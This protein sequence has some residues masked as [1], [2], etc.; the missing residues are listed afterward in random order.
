MRR[1][2]QNAAEFNFRTLVCCDFCSKGNNF[3]TLNQQTSTL[4]LLLLDGCWLNGGAQA[5]LP[6]L[7]L[8]LHSGP[9]FDYRCPAPLFVLVAHW[10]KLSLQWELFIT[11]LNLVLLLKLFKTSKHGLSLSHLESWR[12][13]GTPLECTESSV[14][15]IAWVYCGKSLILAL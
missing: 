4:L 5:L 14:G 1:D 12:W 8:S 15:H 2:E 3:R 11:L 10:S 7:P 13:I 6:L 9:R